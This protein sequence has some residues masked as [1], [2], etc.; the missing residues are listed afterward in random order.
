M[1]GFVL[2]GFVFV[3]IGLELPT[4]L[5][6]L[7]ARE[8]VEIIGLVTAVCVVVVVAR[9]VWVFAAS[10]I[11]GSPRQVVARSNPR[12][13]QRLTFIVSWSGLRGA[14]SL[15]AALALPA[16]FP[17]RNLILL[18][19]FAVILVTLVGQGLT[20]PFL[21]RRAGWDGMELDGDEGTVARA[22]AYEAG[23]AEIERARPAWPGHQ[24]LLDRLESGLRDRSQHLATEDPAETAERRQERIEHEEIQV[25]VI[26]AQRTA[27]IELRDRG[28]INDQTLRAIEREL[29]LEELRMEG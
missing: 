9:F 26:R 5:Q 14:V 15:A 24:P 27:V 25:G 17:E 3:L 13:A 7:G 21:V 1:I 10:H 2:N 11:P 18:V 29:D 16:S 23:L 19:T 28:E 6:G 4:V 8:P 22:A 20:L 12:L